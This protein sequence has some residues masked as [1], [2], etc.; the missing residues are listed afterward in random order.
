MLQNNPTLK[1]HI[2]KL[3]NN[4]WSGG[5][6]NPLTAIEQI[7]YLLFMKQLDK[8]ETIA[9]RNV[10]EGF[11]EEKDYN[12]R[13]KGK[14]QPPGTTKEKDAIDK[15]E[16]RWSV[17]KH[18]PAEEMLL[19]IQTKVFPFLKD[20]NKLDELDV[21]TGKK[22]NRQKKILLQSTWQTLCSLCRKHLC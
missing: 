22:K 7:T 17:F 1:S 11:I 16:L 4:F 10:N 6:A 13:F 2:D 5:I 20:L 12:F 8:N 21:E 19:L 9:E 18:K 14:Y 15:N 3:W